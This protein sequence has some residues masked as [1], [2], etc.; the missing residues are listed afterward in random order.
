LTL[1]FY[2][3][4]RPPLLSLAI[5]EEAARH[6]RAPTALAWTSWPAVVVGRTSRPPDYDCRAAR[7]AGVPVYRRRSGGGAVVLGPG[8]LAVA[9]VLPGWPARRPP[10][11]LGAS[12]L[13]GALRGLGLDVWIENEGDIVVG[14]PRGGS[15]KVGGSAA[16][17]LQGTPVYHA[18][19]IVDEPVD[20]MYTLTPPRLDR[21]AEGR[22]TPVKYRPMSL[23]RLA[24]V[25][26]KRLVQALREG[27]S[28]EGVPIYWAYRYAREKGLLEGAVGV[29]RERMGDPA[30]R[31]CLAP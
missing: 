30:W 23:A 21:V 25:S 4:P 9:V 1:D 20:K 13:A 3:P 29:A 2:P 31:P 6:A 26:R 12:L 19:I 8:V 11:R 24:G 10:T 14:D 15:W 18:T 17:T 28:R 7:L 5:E 22:V 16:Y 27:L